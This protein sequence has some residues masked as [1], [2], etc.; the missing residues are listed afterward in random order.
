M[1]IFIRRDAIKMKSNKKTTVQIDRNL[2]QKVK[3]LAIEYDMP[4]SAVIEIIL[5]NAFRDETIK[6]T[7]NLHLCSIEIDIEDKVSS[8]DHEK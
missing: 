8:R 2:M 4:Y 5:C 6:N 1:I 3:M 7:I